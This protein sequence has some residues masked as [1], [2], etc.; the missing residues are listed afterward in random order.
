MYML[1]FFERF[2][3]IRAKHLAEPSG[4]LPVLTRPGLRARIPKL[5]LCEPFARAPLTVALPYALLH[6]TLTTQR[7]RLRVAIV[8][9]TAVPSSSSRTSHSGPGVIDATRRPLPHAD[10][11]RCPREAESKLDLTLFPP[12]RARRDAPH[13]RCWRPGL[14][15]VFPGALA[16][17]VTFPFAYITSAPTSTTFTPAP[18]AIRTGTTR[19]ALE[20]KR[21]VHTRATDP[22]NRACHAAPAP[23]ATRS[24]CARCGICGGSTSGRL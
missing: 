22:T 8:A 14:R 4:D 6:V 9:A 24:R 2:E 10:F 13:G 1:T 3:P 11:R 17:A 16:V 21:W 7:T 12:A 20:R 15:D 23:R 19:R 18:L 5:V